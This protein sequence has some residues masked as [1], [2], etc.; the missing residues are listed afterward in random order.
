MNVVYLIKSY[1]SKRLFRRRIF[2]KYTFITHLYP[3]PPDDGGRIVTFNTIKELRK[4]GHNIFLC[5]FAEK[6][7]SLKE[8]PLDITYSVIPFSYKNSYDKL[9]KNLFQKNLIIWKNI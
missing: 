5:T 2:E 4:Y 3:Y 9:I 7:I 6:D 1:S 8:I